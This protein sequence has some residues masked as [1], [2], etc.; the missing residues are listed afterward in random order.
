MFCVAE[1][2]RAA[3]KVEL[4]AYTKKGNVTGTGKA[5]STLSG[6]RYFFAVRQETFHEMCKTHLSAS[7]LCSG[8]GNW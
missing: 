5:W 2:F 8:G 3:T 6:F 7:S 4:T 1:M